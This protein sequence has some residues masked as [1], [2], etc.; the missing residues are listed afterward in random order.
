MQHCTLL[1]LASWYPGKQITHIQYTCYNMVETC[2]EL[3]ILWNKIFLIFAVWQLL[4]VHYRTRQSTGPQGKGVQTRFQT[5]VAPW[6]HQP[7]W[8]QQQNHDCSERPG[9]RP[10]H[11]F[12]V[13]DQAIAKSVW[14]VLHVIHMILSDPVPV[15]SRASECG[16]SSHACAGFRRHQ[17]AGIGGRRCHNKL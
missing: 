5:S 8:S 14:S 15:G 16:P 10:M 4:Y 17:P 6:Y 1:I 13:L 12:L 2:S 3:W 11:C 9:E 7:S